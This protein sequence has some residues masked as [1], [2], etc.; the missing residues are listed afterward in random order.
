VVGF[1]ADDEILIRYLT[2]GANLRK[3]VSQSSLHSL[4]GKTPLVLQSNSNCSA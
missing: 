2:P 4:Y 3:P 1:E